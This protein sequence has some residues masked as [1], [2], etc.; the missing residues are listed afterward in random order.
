[1][2][3]NFSP[4]KEK[5]LLIL[6][7]DLGTQFRE[8]LDVVCAMEIYFCWFSLKLNDPFTCI[9]NFCILSITLCACLF[10]F[11]DIKKFLDL[12]SSLEDDK[13]SECLL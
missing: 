3:I 10:F 12:F 2:Y 11:Q 9:W 1:M 5:I 4:I 6:H 7:K 13:W 8:D